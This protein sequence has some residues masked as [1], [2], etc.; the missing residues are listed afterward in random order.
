MNLNYIPWKIKF[1]SSSSSSLS[2][3][4]KVRKLPQ[5]L[6]PLTSPEIDIS[7]HGVPV[8]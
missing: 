2:L 5:L 8:V 4:L 7:H 3:N 1:S 6:E